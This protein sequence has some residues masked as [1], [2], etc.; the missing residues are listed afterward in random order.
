MG[1]PNKSISFAFFSEF[2]ERNSWTP[3][4][5]QN[6]PHFTP[7]VLK[8]EFYVAII[9]SQVKAIWNPAAAATPLIAQRLI[10]GNFLIA[11]KVLVHS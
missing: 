4:V 1:S 10:I 5:E 3:G 11:N 8:L 6:N 2:I 7:G 9:I